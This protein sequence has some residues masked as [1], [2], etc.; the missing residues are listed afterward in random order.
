MEPMHA[1][2]AHTRDGPEQLVYET[3]PIPRLRP[4][5][6]LVKVHA[7][8]ITPSELGWDLSWTDR[9][10]NPRTPVIPS[11]EI[12]GEVVEVAAEAPRS[13]V[14][15][16]VFA[17]TAFDRDGGAAEYVAVH[18]ADLA[19]K[20]TKLSHVEAATLP[21]PALTAWQALFDHATLQSGQHVLVHGAAGGVGG[22]A[23]QVAVHAG[24]RVSATCRSGDVGYVRDLGADQ[25]VAADREPFEDAIRDVDVV[26]DNLGGETQAR[27]WPL[28]RRGGM[29]IT[30]A[31]PPDQ[32]L[33]DRHGVRGVFFV[34]RPDRDELTEIARLADSGKLRP[35]VGAT[36]RLD[37]GP[38]AY[39]HR[40]V[41]GA[42]GKIVL[43]VIA[44]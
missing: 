4:E 15:E 32:T 38:A 22:F 24:A 44:D 27:T 39:R 3:T 26:L 36:Y 11:H 18:A 40:L 16:Q 2:R 13:L 43:E 35:L 5:D 28:I 10:G 14:G 1:V 42:R 20:P 33:A 17:L 23:V 31:A 41:P 25:V 7:A 30:L 12:A 37:Q 19:A 21:L 6:A 8:A 29:L 34:V 9:E